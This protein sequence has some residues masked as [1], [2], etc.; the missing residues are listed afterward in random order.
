MSDP[1]LTYLEDHKAG[2]GVAI[3]LLKKMKAG[4]NGEFLSQFAENILAAVEEDEEI[5]L[6]LATALGTDSN[7][8]KKAAAWVSEKA[9]RVK[10]GTAMSGDFGTFEAL[11]FLALGIQGKLHLWYALQVLAVTDSRL[12]SLDYKALIARAEEQYS[13][14]EGR[15]LALATLALSPPQL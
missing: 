10:L 2:A 9:S 8:M 14:M 5:L 6:K 15:R 12:R 11:E 7:M 1:L 3:A 4:A 13:K